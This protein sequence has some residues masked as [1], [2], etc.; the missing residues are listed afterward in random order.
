[1]KKITILE[2]SFYLKFQNLHVN[3]NYSVLFKIKEENN[4]IIKVL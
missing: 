1:M 4:S 3:E 2:P